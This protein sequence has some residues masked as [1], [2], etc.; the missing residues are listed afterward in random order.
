MF[1]ADTGST[2]QFIFLSSALHIGETL[3][4]L[5]IF[6]SGT[7]AFSKYQFKSDDV[8]TDKEL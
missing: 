3:K 1:P 4:T 8:D 5:R 6:P 2:A 7:H